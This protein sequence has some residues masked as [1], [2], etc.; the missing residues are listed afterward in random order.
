MTAD[1]IVGLALG[2]VL[3]V[4]GMLVWGM[5]NGMK[6]QAAVSP[7]KALTTPDEPEA[8]A[9]LIDPSNPPTWRVYKPR[10]DG[11]ERQKCHCHGKYLEVGQPVM[12]WPV[13]DGE[14]G[15][16]ELLCEEGVGIDAPVP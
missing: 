3:G 12:L 7:S 9:R 8:P 5:R 16:I 4:M 15:Q 13:P 2:V 11:G 6:Q 14:P 10:Y 1:L